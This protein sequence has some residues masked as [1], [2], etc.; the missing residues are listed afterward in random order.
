MASRRRLTPARLRG[1]A[2]DQSTAL[3]SAARC[4]DR[5]QQEQNIAAHKDGCALLMLAEIVLQQAG[6]PMQSADW[7]NATADVISAVDA[8]RGVVT[9]GGDPAPVASASVKHLRVVPPQETPFHVGIRRAYT[10]DDQGNL[11]PKEPA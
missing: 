7:R 9:V 11:Y 2:R 10:M 8:E 4:I 5:L 1:M 6:E 3:V